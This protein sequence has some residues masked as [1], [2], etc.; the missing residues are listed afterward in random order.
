MHSSSH[1]GQ[2]VDGLLTDKATLDIFWLKDDSPA[3]PENLP[4][5]EVIA[6][7]IVDDLEAAL[8]QLRPIAGD[9]GV[10]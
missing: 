7:D 2:G 4:P 8:D 9:P 6:H 10:W 3:D 1:E 5:P